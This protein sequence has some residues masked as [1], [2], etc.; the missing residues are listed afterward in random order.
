MLHKQLLEQQPQA[1]QLPQLPQPQLLATGTVPPSINTSSG[2]PFPSARV[3]VSR[4]LFCSGKG[5]LGTTS[6]GSISNWASFDASR[7][8][9]FLLIAKHFDKMTEDHNSN[10]SQ[11]SSSLRPVVELVER[12]KTVNIFVMGSRSDLVR[13]YCRR[14]II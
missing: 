2:S 9:D 3:S 12:R 14:G 1:P 10:F 13:Y 6:S 8:I 7:V 11:I 4:F 5:A